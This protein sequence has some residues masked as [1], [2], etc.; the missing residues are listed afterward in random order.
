[1]GAARA[2]AIGG[3][4]LPPYEL[5]PNG[6]RQE[7]D[8][9]HP[10]GGPS[11][12]NHDPYGQDRS[13][14][15]GTLPLGLSCLDETM[16]VNFM[17]QMMYMRQVRVYCVSTVCVSTVCV[18]TV[19]SFC[20]CVYRV[21]SVSTLC[22]LCVYRAHTTDARVLEAIGRELVREGTELQPMD[23]VRKLY[24]NKTHDQYVKHFSRLRIARCCK[25]QPAE[26]FSMFGHEF[27]CS[28]ICGRHPLVVILC[29]F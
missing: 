26:V 10:M 29:L 8:S 20:Y 17:M 16:L 14:M 9:K 23:A 15:L 2:A 25:F 18:Y 21:Y 22:L 19:C 5:K 24:C 1:M 12:E 6:G 11:E 27:C 4:S 13:L 7:E 3:P 28:V